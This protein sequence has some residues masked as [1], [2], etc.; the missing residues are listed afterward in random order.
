MKLKFSKIDIVLI[1]ISLV[2]VSILCF[3]WY[4]NYTKTHIKEVK[5]VDGKYSGYQLFL[6][7]EYGGYGVAGQDL[8][9]GKYLKKYNISKGDYLFEPAFGGE[10]IFSSKTQ[11]SSFDKPHGILK[12]ESF[13]SEG[14]NIKIKGED[15]FLLFDEEVEVSSNVQIDDG[16]NYS[17]IVKIVK[18]DK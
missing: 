15:R 18:L 12:I 13:T 14:A 5:K 8:G 6:T 17:Y 3:I 7:V 9:S 4:S 11:S 10:W 2:A 16:T 1:I